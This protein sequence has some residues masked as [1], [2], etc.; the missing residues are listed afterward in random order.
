MR[1][2]IVWTLLAAL[3]LAACEG[4]Q[5]A[6]PTPAATKAAVSGTDAEAGT[7]ATTAEADARRGPWRLVTLGDAYTA[8]Y[9]TEL[10][11]RDSWPAQVAESLKRAEM[12][13][14]PTNLAAR[15]VSS[16]EVL[17]LQV[18]QV[19]QIQPDVVTVQVGINDLLYPETGYRDNLAGIF[20]RLLEVLPAERIFAITTPADASDTPGVDP[21]EARADIDRLN[22]VLIDVAAERGIEVIDIGLVNQLGDHDTSMGVEDGVYTYPS[23]KQYAGWAEVIGPYV[24]GALA[25]I[26]P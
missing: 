23:A 22:G 13:V 25:A 26:E 2:I 21:E 11:R 9:A 3:A 24:Y 4:A 7:G 17:E 16:V 10:P 12:H 20:D 15:S 6:A 19:E 1:T 14:R 18:G 8:G 5:T